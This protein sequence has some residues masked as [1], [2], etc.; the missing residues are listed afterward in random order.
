MHINKAQIW[1][2]KHRQREWGREGHKAKKRGSDRRIYIFFFYLV[3]MEIR[4]LNRILI[5]FYPAT[6]F[7]LLIALHFDVPFH[8]VSVFPFQ[9]GAISY[10]LALTRTCWTTTASQTSI[11]LGNKLRSKRS[12]GELSE[13]SETICARFSNPMDN[14]T[15]FSP[16]DTTM[17]SDTYPPK[18]DCILKITGWYCV[19]A[20]GAPLCCM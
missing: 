4:A 15:F 17:L 18:V 10:T 5:F 11:T 2:H 8:L 9:I 14:K 6:S 13:S 19:C 20:F 3:T 16:I 12:Q 7:F 1:L